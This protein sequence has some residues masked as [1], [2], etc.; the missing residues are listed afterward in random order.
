MQALHST[1]SGIESTE[2]EEEED[3]DE[4][5]HVAPPPLKAEALHASLVARIKSGLFAE[6]LRMPS[7]P[8]S[9]VGAMEMRWAVLRHRPGACADAEGVTADPRSWRW[10]NSF[11]LR[12]GAICRRR[13]TT[14]LLFP[15]ARLA[16]VTAATRGGL[17]RLGRSL[18][19]RGNTLLRCRAQTYRR[20][21]WSVSR[22]SN[23]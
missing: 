15:S 18:L 6:L 12:A 7:N 3:D 19:A 8:S 22:F 2:E 16:A 21:T 5:V 10:L 13:G 1:R 23:F 11:R 9:P 17:W 4:E 20:R 14:A